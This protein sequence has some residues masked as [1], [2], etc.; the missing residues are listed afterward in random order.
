MQNHVN[1]HHLHLYI[2]DR[3][4]ELVL[5][6]N[7]LSAIH[8]QQARVAL[9]IVG[10]F[11]DTPAIQQP[12]QQQQQQGNEEHDQLRR[13]VHELQRRVEHHDN[14]LQRLVHQRAVDD[15]HT[16]M[17][18]TVQLSDEEEEDNIPSW[19]TAEMRA[20]YLQTGMAPL[21]AAKPNEDG[22]AQSC[23]TCR[24]ADVNESGF[25]QCTKGAFEGDSREPKCRRHRHAHTAQ[26]RLSLLLQSVAVRLLAVVDTLVDCAG[27]KVR[28]CAQ[29]PTRSSS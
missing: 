13:Q 2:Q 16:H 21:S 3:N 24:R 15:P 14:T 10:N 19:W 12:P 26:Q 9:G 27:S 25:V 28:I 1:Q 6:N 29:L 18:E 22:G 8:R 7:R 20:Y 5:H 17:D 11:V 23:H 4:Q